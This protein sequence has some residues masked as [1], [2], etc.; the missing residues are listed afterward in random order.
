MPAESYTKTGSDVAL[1]LKRQFGDSD[2][3][4]ITDADILEWINVAQQEI[5][6]QNPILKDT[7]QTASIAGQDAY[8]YPASLNIQYIEAVHYDGVP[9][10]ALSFQEAQAYLLAHRDFNDVEGSP[11]I[12]YERNGTLYLY[13]KPSESTA[14]VIRMFF[15]RRP[16]DL[17]TISDPLDLP[18]RYFQRILDLCLAKAY[19]LDENWEA[20]QYKQSEFFSGMNM[21]A[22]QENV[23][24][25]NTYPAPTVRVEDL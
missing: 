10:E 11:V 20:A 25:T 7:M 8:S 19:Q 4:Q 22:N 15:I 23:V 14:D 16:E 13:P 24:R 12:W 5:V 2:G 9:L 6:S 3:R 18:D 17:A 21:L 1:A